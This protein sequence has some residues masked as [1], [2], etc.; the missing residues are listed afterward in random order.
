MLI[1]GSRRLHQCDDLSSNSHHVIVTRISWL[2]QKARA[3]PPSKAVGY[4]TVGIC[5]LLDKLHITIPTFFLFFSCLFS[6]LHR[7]V[8]GLSGVIFLN[9][10]TK[11]I[12]LM[13]FFSLVWVK[14]HRITFGR[15]SKFQYP[16]LT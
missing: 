7:T 2:A 6:F 15:R 5:S 12:L 4:L 11:S 13:A 8:Q 1:R 9:K 3:I 10:Y 16:L 14:R